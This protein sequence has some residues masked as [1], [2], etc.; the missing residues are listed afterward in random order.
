ME[1]KILDTKYIAEITKKETIRYFMRIVEEEP[2]EHDD[3]FDI[4]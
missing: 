4:F 3:F 1:R 2:E